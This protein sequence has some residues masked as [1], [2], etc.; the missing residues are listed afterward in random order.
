MITISKR[1]CPCSYI[2]KKQKIAKSLYIY[3]KKQTPFKKQD[4]LRY[5][6]IYKKLDTFRHAIF[7]ENFEI[8]ICIEKHNTLRYVIFLYKKSQ[9]LREKQDNLRYFFNIQKSWH[10]ALRGF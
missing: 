8:V 4:N 5:V 7:H 1:Q 2:Y 6:F 3:A 9:T 10:F